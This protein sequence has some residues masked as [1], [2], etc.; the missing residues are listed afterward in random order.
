MRDELIKRICAD[1]AS[2][3]TGPGTNT[4]L[5]GI[6]DITLVDPGPL[7]ESRLDNVVAQCGDKLK[8]V[9]VTHTHKDHSPGEL[10]LIHISEPTRPY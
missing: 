2:M 10:S 8:R 3:F 6:E 5:I 7:Q 4:Y 1:N 9:L